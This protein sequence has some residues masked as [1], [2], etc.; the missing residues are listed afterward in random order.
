MPEYDGRALFEKLVLDGFQAGLSWIT[1]LR[2]REPFR[3]RLRRLRAGGDRRAT[4]PQKVAALMA[5]AGIVRNRAKIEGAIAS[6]RAWLALEEQRR[7]LARFCGTSST[8]GR[9]Q[10]RLAA[11]RRRP[12]RDAVSLGAL[13][14][15]EGARLPLRRSDH[16]LCLH[17]GGRDGQRSPR[18][19]LS[20]R[21]LRRRSAEPARERA[22]ARP[23]GPAAPRA[24]QRMLSGRRLDLLDPSPLDIEIEDI[25]HGLARVAR[26]NGQTLG[27]AIFSVAQHCCWSR[28]S[29]SRSSPRC[30]RGARLAVLL[31]DAPEYVIGDMISPFKAVIGDAY[32]AVEA[33]L[34][35]AIHLR[36]GLPA[37]PPAALR[38][39]IKQADRIAAFSRRRGSPAS[40]AEEARAFLRPA[41]RARGR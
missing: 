37:E 8:A 33:R 12:G 34:L 24:W 6:A 15:A 7:V 21:R 3:A 41:G 4:T 29:P 26:W 1:I 2:K 18:R 27:R 10:N 14:G 28:R 36:F 17:A 19:L 13:E 39:R 22:A 11:P 25:A 30:P 20:P 40:R 38:R 32:R 31:H 35:A 5:D 23:R 16:R 9:S